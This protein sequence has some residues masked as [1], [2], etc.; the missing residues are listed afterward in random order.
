[1]VNDGRVA[2]LDVGEE[3]GLLNPAVRKRIGPIEDHALDGSELSGII[4]TSP[5]CAEHEWI[6]QVPRL[7]EHRSWADGP[8]RESPEGTT[9]DAGLAGARS[10][11]LDEDVSASFV[12]ERK[13]I[14]IEPKAGVGDHVPRGAGNRP[15]LP[16]IG[17]STMA[18]QVRH[19]GA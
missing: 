15:G 2:R 11:L 16:K 13:R 17:P 12:N 9:G 10:R 8:A 1:M 18:S 7:L 5:E 6:G 19:R 3:D 4:Q 14:G